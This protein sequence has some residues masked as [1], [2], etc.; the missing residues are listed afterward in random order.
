M[1]VLPIHPE[2]EAYLKRH[3][4]EKKFSKQTRLLRQNIHHPSLAVE[5]LEPRHLRFFSF[6]VDRKYRAIFIFHNR[7]TIEI[8]DVNNHY[9]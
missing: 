4:L 1:E 5:L 8:I 3:R 6:R 2:I 7:G 9:Q